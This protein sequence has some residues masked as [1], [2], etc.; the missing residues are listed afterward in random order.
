MKIG[1]MIAAVMALLTLIG[2]G[3]AYE[4]SLQKDVHQ[5]MDERTVSTGVELDLQRIDLELKM[6]RLIEERRVL[7][8]DELARKEYLEAYR[9]ILIQQQKEQIA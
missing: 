1:T 9:L 4:K 8:P 5:T 6:F 3:Y 2:S 7:T